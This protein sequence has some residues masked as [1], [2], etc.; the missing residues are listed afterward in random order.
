MERT[1]LVKVEEP[2]IHHVLAHGH[3]AG[4]VTQSDSILVG[5]RMVFLAFHACFRIADVDN[6]RKRDTD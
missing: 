6:K 4:R 2:I 3:V 5:V 1:Q